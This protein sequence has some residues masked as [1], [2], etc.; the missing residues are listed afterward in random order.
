MKNN[1]KVIILIGLPSSGK[2]TWAKNFIAKNQNY[3]RISRDDFR[4]MLKNQQICNNTIENLISE[5]CENTIIKSLVKKQ[6]IIID[7]TNLKLKYI[8][9]FIKLTQY[10]ADIE[11]ILFDVSIEECIKRDKNREN[12]VG[13]RV[14]KKMNNDLK[15]L[16]EN[17]NFQFIKKNTDKKIIKPDFNSSLSDAVCFDVDGTL[18]I[19]GNRSPYD[20]NKINLD[21]P[22]N[23][24][25]EHIKFHKNLKRKIIILSGRDSKCKELTEKWLK[26]YN[27]HYDYIFMR[28]ENDNRKD[29]II[30]KELYEENIKNKFNLLCCYDDRFQ[31]TKGW[32][33]LNIFTFCCN[34]GLI[35]F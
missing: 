14:I 17:F 1:L 25:I 13:E 6:N 16:K 30:K 12:S 5:L 27:I 8:N 33:D 11:Y 26:Y 21:I 2:T 23:I 10:Y 34:Q 4:L 29:S 32:Y 15:I 35:E 18:T 19:M 20:W 22:N 3:I 31:T 28:K 7:N 24:V 9:N